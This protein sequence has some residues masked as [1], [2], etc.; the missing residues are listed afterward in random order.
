MDFEPP[1]LPARLEAA[2]WLRRAEASGGFAMVLHK[3]D[4]DAGTIVLVSL[5]IQ[6]GP[7]ACAT[8]WERLPQPDGARLWVSTK[9]QDPESKQ[10]FN[11]YIARRTARDPDLWVLEL[12][13]ANPQQFIGNLGT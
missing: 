5:D 9:V 8:L 11:D 4:P 3:G 12:T 2:A 10:D 1:R 13:V 6:G 7:H